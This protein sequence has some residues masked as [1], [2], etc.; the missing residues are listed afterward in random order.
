MARRIVS[1]VQQGVIAQNEF[2]K[3]LMMGSGGRLEAAA[4]LTDEERRDFEIHI[5]GQ[6][7]VA[8]AIQVKSVM[9]L[10][11]LS[12][13]VRSLRSFFKVRASDL[14]NDPLFYY[15]Y[16]FLDP[17][18]MG[19]MD[20]T[21]LVPSTVFHAQASPVRHGDFW[22]FSFEASMEPDSHDKWV[23][24][25]VNVAD[26]GHKVLSILEELRRQQTTSPA[27][28]RLLQVPGLIWAR[29]V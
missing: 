2:I 21:F 22:R 9:Q 24:Y 17:V 4:P 11:H 27:A 18:S 23:A 5:H 12:K 25:R 19:L 26:L 1:L 14:V 7:G 15:F 6:F 20:P 8:L 3:F 10:T 28:G 29:T 13:N 16:A